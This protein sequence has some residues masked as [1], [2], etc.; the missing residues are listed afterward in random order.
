MKTEPPPPSGR[1]RGS[2]EEATSWRFSPL[3]RGKAP[4]AS[5][6]D[7]ASRG[8]ERERGARSD[9]RE[10][11]RPTKKME[12]AGRAELRNTKG[13]KTG[14]EEEDGPGGPACLPAGLI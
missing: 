9:M 11:S 4:L 1:R 6:M 5:A 3:P 7:G 12:L 2:D 14:R 8:M 10:T 13:E